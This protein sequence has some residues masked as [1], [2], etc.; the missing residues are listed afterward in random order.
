M[1]FNLFFSIPAQGKKQETT[2]HAPVV[3]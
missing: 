2:E 3:F 1:Y